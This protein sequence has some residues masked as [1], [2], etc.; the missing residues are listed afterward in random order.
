MEKLKIKHQFD[1]H[2]NHR[3]VITNGSIRYSD[4]FPFNKPA[5]LHTRDGGYVA[6]TTYNLPLGG[7]VDKIYELRIHTSQYQNK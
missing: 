5:I 6:Y 3:I 4:W 2:G 1:K 7:E